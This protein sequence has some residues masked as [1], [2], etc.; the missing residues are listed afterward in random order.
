MENDLSLIHPV[1]EKVL[2][3]ATL[4]YGEY[5]ESYRTHLSISLTEAATN[6][7]VHGNLEISSAWLSDGENVFQEM[8]T[9]RPHDASFA[10]RRAIVAVTMDRRQLSFAVRDQGPGFQVSQ[11]PDPTAPEN[12]MKAGGRG[13]MLMRNFMDAVVHNQQGNEVLMIKHAPAM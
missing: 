5:D 2:E 8:L 12:I 6:A 13:L 9:K 10:E 1:I 11:V 7:I 3:L 4:I